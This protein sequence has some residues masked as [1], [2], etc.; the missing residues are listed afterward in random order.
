MKVAP[1]EQWL[2]QYVG[3]QRKLC[4]KDNLWCTIKGAKESNGLLC[5]KMLLEF[6]KVVAETKDKYKKQYK[7][8]FPSEWAVTLG[9]CL[10]SVSTCARQLLIRV[11]EDVNKWIREGFHSLVLKPFEEELKTMKAM[12]LPLIA[13]GE[14]K[15]F[16][17]SG[18]AL[19][20]R[21]KMFWT[22]EGSSWSL[23]LQKQKH[24]VADFCLNNSLHLN[25]SYG[26]A[27]EEFKK[28]RGKALLDACVAWNHL[29]GS[30]KY[31]IKLLDADSSPSIQLA[32]VQCD[33][34]GAGLNSDSELDRASASEGED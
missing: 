17:H 2:V 16:H 7:N 8:D 24:N 30:G 31:W 1:N 22:P 18:R 21:D 13:C 10:I 29:D 27:G 15:L 34:D 33:I 25:V 6:K 5:K 9:G 19:G 32:L 28:A 12:S 3:Y 14:E 26:P 20:V 4:R 11:G 23:K